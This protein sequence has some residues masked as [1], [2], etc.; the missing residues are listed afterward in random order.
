MFHLV[1]DFKK[2]VEIVKFDYPVEQQDDFTDLPVCCHLEDFG[3]CKPKV[4]FLN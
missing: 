4:S 2:E 3:L 1:Q